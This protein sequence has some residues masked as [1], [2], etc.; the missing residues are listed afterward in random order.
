MGLHYVNGALVNAGVVDRHASS[1]RDLT[2]RKPNGHLK[3][4]GADFLVIADAW[5]KKN[6]GPPGAHGTAVP[7]LGE[8]QSLR[9]PGLLHAACLGLEGE[10][11][12]ARS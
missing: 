4:I 2:K 12:T 6:Q 11:P 5:D 8:S 9:A 7:L 1:D 10:T 3:L